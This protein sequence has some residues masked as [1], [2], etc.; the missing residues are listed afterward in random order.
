MPDTKDPLRLFVYG[1]L[2]EGFFNYK[3]SLEGKVISRTTGKV[4]GILYHLKAKGYPAMIPGDGWVSGEV[5]EV[6]DFNKVIQMVDEI[7]EYLGPNRP[8]NQYERQV[9]EIE[10]A[11]GTKGSAWV[12]WYSR[13]DLGSPENPVI[14]ILSGNWRE[15]MERSQQ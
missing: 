8:E 5:L 9:S 1:S 6:D 15:F 12:Y 10:L 7:E 2:M 13:N 3:K 14:P 4:R 11:N